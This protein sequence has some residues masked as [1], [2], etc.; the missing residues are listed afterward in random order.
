MKYIVTKNQSGEVV[1]NDNVISFSNPE[2]IDPKYATE[3]TL[4]IKTSWFTKELSGIQGKAIIAAKKV[5]NN[6]FM[7]DIN[8]LKGNVTLAIK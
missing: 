4:V 3:V 8:P 1:F 7:M 2:K 6:K 5:G